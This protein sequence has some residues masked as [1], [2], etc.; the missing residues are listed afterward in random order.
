MRRIRTAL[1]LVNFMPLVAAAQSVSQQPVTAAVTQRAPY[2]KRGDEVDKRYG[3]HRATL[4]ILFDVLTHELKTEAPEL[5][6]K[7]APPALVAYGYQILPVLQPTPPWRPRPSRIIVSPFSWN[8]TDSMIDR[9]RDSLS[10]TKARLDTIE[11]VKTDERR[12][13]FGIIADEYTKLVAGQKLMA[14]T[15]AYNRLWQGEIARDPQFY[16]KTRALQDAA[17]AHQLLLDSASTSNESLRAGLKQRV[18]SLT[19]RIDSAI[20]KLPTPEFARITRP[21]PNRWIVSVPVF[22]DITD[23]VFIQRFQS[24]VEDAWHVRDANEEFVLTLEIHRVP[25]TDLYAESEAPIAGARIDIARHVARFPSGGVILTTGGSSIYATGRSIILGPHSIPMSALAHEFGHM[26][27]FKDGYFRSYQ[28]EGPDGYRVLEM[29]LDSENVVAAPEN[30]RVRHDHFEQI[31][32]ERQLD[33][34]I[35]R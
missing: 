17:L 32:R 5:L 3:E 6:Q 29:I 4:E 15:M 31:L 14:S 20:K 9:G 24:A 23:T 1:W 26:L 13:E 2:L 22:T 21:S 16:R 35:T 18:D 11:R 27:G 25:V 10:R 30:G 34:S 28:D 33:H 8:R 12:R 7:I 19:M